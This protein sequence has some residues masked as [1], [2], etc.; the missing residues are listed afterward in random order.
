MITSQHII[1]KKSK[2]HDFATRA[3]LS[4]PLIYHSTMDEIASFCPN[5][6]TNFHI[7]EN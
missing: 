7:L 5:T 4:S 6:I 1:E 2:K 3:A